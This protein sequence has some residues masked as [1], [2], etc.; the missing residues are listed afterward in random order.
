MEVILLERIDNLGDI[1][2]KV[3][4]KPG[5]GRNF[6]I[7]KG[8]AAPATAE[9]VAKLEARRAELEQ[10]AQQGLNAAKTRA[11]ALQGLTVEITAKSGVEGRLFGSVGTA[12]IADACSEKGLHVQR[13]EVRLS[14]GP[15][16]MVGEHEIE[17]HL[18]T[19]V[20]V[21]VVVK[22]VGDVDESAAAESDQD[23]EPV[24]DG[25]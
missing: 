7:P 3:N 12:D 20:S 22:V 23:D 17:L 14:D 2:D 4:V 18:H 25:E 6:L 9:N 24:S 13:S 11:E 15:L 10:K 5:F 19:D 1:G 16:R 21:P 8:K